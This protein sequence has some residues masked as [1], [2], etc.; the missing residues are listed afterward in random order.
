M[1]RIVIDLPQGLTASGVTLWAARLASGVVER[2]GRAALLVHRPAEN[3]SALDV[4]IHRGVEVVDL[5]NL[6]PLAAARGRIAPFAHAWARA[7]SAVDATARSPAVLSPNLLGDSYGAA[8]AVTLADGERA[9][10]VGWQHSDIEYD[11]RVLAHYEPVI[12]RFVG[13]SER[14]T[15]LLRSAM[16]ARAADVERLWYGVT[17]PK[18]APVRRPGPVLLAYVGRLEHA[19]KRVL[20]LPELAR[21]LS[22]SD[23][24]H[25]L[26]IAGDGP[27]RDGLARACEGLT[28]VRLLGALSPDQTRRLLESSHAMVLGSRYEGLSVGMLEAMAAGCVPI[29]TRVESGIAEAIIDGQSGIICDCDPASD[30]RAAG[31]A[32]ADGV[33]RAVRLGM[34]RLS[35][36]THARA[37]E[38]SIDLHLDRACSLI[39]S[40][41]RDPPRH[42]PGERPC[43]FTAGSEPGAASGTVPH[44]ARERLASV[45]GSLAGRSVVIHGAGAHTLAM[46]D[47]LARSP[48]RVVAISD[49]DR[50]RHGSSLW[51][52][53]VIA[54][55]DAQAHGATDVVISSWLHE[56]AIHQRRAV[57]ERQGL[58]VHRLYAP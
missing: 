6:P 11:R 58:A 55:A 9:R 45:L 28:S 50:G 24:S 4:P 16:P 18:A 53:P 19:Q 3:Q 43:A 13:V 32:L 47:V 5:S 30:E 27:A 36:A 10:I 49:D 41:M 56:T 26:A 1:V 52:W 31:G 38:F 29:V 39:A 48:A 7:L 54:P 37:R 20:C 22:A 25:E 21:A 44:D 42:W 2:G 33:R 34:D 12:A 23:V 51:G 15:G 57:Y 35:V 17:V 46:A 14:I 8:A 40:A